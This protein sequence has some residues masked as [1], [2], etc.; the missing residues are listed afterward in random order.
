MQDATVVDDEEVARLEAK[1]HLEA[2]V[3]EQAPEAE[4][5]VV[6]GGQ[7][8]RRHRRRLHGARVEAHGTHGA[9]RIELDQGRGRAQLGAIVAIGECHAVAGEQGEVG[10]VV[11]AQRLRHAEAVDERALAAARARG[12]AVQ[13]LQRRHRVAVGIVRVRAQTERRVGEVGRL[14]DRAH[15]EHPPVVRHPHV[16]EQLCHSRHLSALDRDARE[17]AE[18]EAGDRFQPPPQ[19]LRVAHDVGVPGERQ[20][21]GD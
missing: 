10:R 16:P 19:L 8:R 5:R 14:D 21:A 4:V 6:P 9:V 3:L 1:P 18:A 7:L 20:L 12:Q 2:R 13:Q 15:V 17:N 11:G